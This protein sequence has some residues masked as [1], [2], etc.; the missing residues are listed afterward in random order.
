MGLLKGGGGSRLQ[1]DMRKP[2]LRAT[3]MMCFQYFGA[4]AFAQMLALD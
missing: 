4:H 2:L 3:A 1:I